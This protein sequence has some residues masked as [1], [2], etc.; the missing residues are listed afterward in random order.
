MRATT[1]LFNGRVIILIMEGT[2]FKNDLFYIIDIKVDG[3]SLHQLNYLFSCVMSAHTT[4]RML[5]SV[6][7]RDG[8]RSLYEL[9]CSLCS[10]RAVWELTAALCCIRKKAIDYMKE[11]MW[12]F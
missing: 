8:I 10:S 2:Y 12:I 5:G 3:I 4:A 1:H 6:F 7:K 9:K 11:Q